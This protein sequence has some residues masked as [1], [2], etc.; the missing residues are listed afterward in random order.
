MFAY[1]STRK[2]DNGGAI[3]Y[4]GHSYVPRVAEGTET[5]ARVTVE[6]R[7]MLDGRIYL[8]LLKFYT[9]EIIDYRFL[10]SRRNN[11]IDGIKLNAKH[12]QTVTLDFRGLIPS[13]ILTC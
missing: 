13:L 2:T 1:R 5:M 6:V 3:S 7:E 11:L 10:P 9:L 8:N 12:L 4:K